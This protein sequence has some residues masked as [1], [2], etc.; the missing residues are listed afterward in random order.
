MTFFARLA[1]FLLLLLSSIPSPSSHA[2]SN[3]P[4]SIYEVEI[5][6]HGETLQEAR[7]DAIRQALQKTMQQ[8]IVV[9]RVI[10]DDKVVRDKIMSTMNGYIDQ[11]QEAS[12]FEENGQIAIQAKISVS[13]ARISN[14]I[15]TIAGEVAAMSGG[16]IFA[17]SQR[18][19]TQSKVMGEV[20]DHLFRG[21][22]SDSINITITKIGIDA[23]SSDKAFVEVHL[24]YSKPWLEQLHSGL[25][26]LAIDHATSK[27]CGGRNCPDQWYIDNASENL[28]ISRQTTAKDI[29]DR[30]TD[31]GHVEFCMM[32]KGHGECFMLPTGDYG[33]TLC[34][35]KDDNPPLLFL[36]ARFVDLTGSSTFSNKANCVFT[37]KLKTI[38]G[39]S[40]I[41]AGIKFRRYDRLSP[42][43]GWQYRNHTRITLEPLNVKTS[44]KINMT[45]IDMNKTVKV[46]I[47][48][49]YGGVKY[50]NNSISLRSG[51][52]G[53]SGW[54]TLSDIANGIAS[55]PDV[56]GTKMDE[57]LLWRQ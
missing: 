57:V 32:Y 13:S 33:K 29:Q 19:A 40:Y 7:N 38:S 8:L 26:A 56:C 41:L 51:K 35:D 48:P 39:N 23:E 1:I 50:Q 18:I 10:Q 46:G 6:G 28:S 43:W 37:D 22:P 36:A 24:D 54:F 44:F 17:E 2:A 45:D 47:V 20:F 21:F 11:F 14:Y 4:Q 49:T 12:I 3:E 25:K 27:K 31:R 16:S 52:P 5:I 15:G 9:D 53:Q 42:G 55:Q 34:L 30:V